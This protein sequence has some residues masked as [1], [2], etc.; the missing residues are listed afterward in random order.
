MTLRSRCAL[1]LM[2]LMSVIA[3]PVVWAHPAQKAEA[4][5]T[6][7]DAAGPPT[8]AELDHFVRAT[9]EIH[10]IVVAAHKKI[11]DSEDAAERDRLERDT[12]AKA[13]KV[14]K[15]YHLTALRYQQIAVAVQSDAATRRKAQ[16]IAQRITSP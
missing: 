4:A 2:A 3:I 12:Q 8:A 11:E 9:G 5:P 14:V 6:S 13:E 15:K 10:G 1:V 7:D 16:A